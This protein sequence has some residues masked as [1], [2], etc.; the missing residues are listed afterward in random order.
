VIEN[1]ATHK[2]KR[3]GRATAATPPPNRSPASPSAHL[4][5]LIIPGNS[6]PYLRLL[7]IFLHAEW[8]LCTFCKQ[9][10]N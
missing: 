10:N 7:F 1:E 4:S 8:A 6:S 2:Q 3:R 9:E 5:K